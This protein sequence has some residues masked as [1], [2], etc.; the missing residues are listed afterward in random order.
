MP[1]LL[2]CVSE[3]PAVV[4]DSAQRPEAHDVVMPVSLDAEPG[5]EEFLDFALCFD[6]LHDVL[7]ISP[8]KHD[9]NISPKKENSAEQMATITNGERYVPIAE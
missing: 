5:L 3:K 1:H 7:I 9:F 6:L 2:V 8:Y 4:T